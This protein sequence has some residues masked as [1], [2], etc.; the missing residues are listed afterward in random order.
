VFLLRLLSYVQHFP[1][2]FGDK[3]VYIVNSSL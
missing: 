3:V 2:F 1:R